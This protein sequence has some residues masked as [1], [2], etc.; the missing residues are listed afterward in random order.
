MVLSAAVVDTHALGHIGTMQNISQVNALSFPMIN[1]F[2]GIQHIDT[3]NHIFKFSYSQLS[4]DLTHFLGDKGKKI[5]HMFG[6]AF[7]FFAQF[8]ILGRDPHRTRVEMAFA[9]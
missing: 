1:G 2:L 5:N 6:P 3:A 8:R 7:K 9:Q 4:H